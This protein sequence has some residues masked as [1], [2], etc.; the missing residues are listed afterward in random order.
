[1]PTE[2][3]AEN[4]PSIRSDP[5]LAKAMSSPVRIR[6]LGMLN[7]A[8]LSPKQ[9]A[10]RLGEPLENVSYH[11]RLL[12]DLG[13]IELVRT[14]KRR[15]ATAHF[16]R[17]T[18]RAFI[19]SDV[20]AGLDDEARSAITSTIL[21][22]SFRLAYTAAARGTFDSRTDRHLSMTNLT[23]TDAG[24]TEL[25]L[26]LDGLVE[27]ALRLQAQALAPEAADEDKVRTDLI[28]AH[29]PAAPAD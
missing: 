14:E 19:D 29:F 26:L 2:T 18:T 8:V 5:R 27:N 1:V 28:L 3:S 13:C 25:N 6:I 23:L 20:S 24:W 22:E 12:R 16:Y 11:V 15:G 4:P 21:Q 7:E 10:E 17:A 9:V